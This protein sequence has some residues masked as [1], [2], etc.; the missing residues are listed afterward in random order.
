MA[1]YLIAKI[2]TG[3]HKSVPEAAY[4]S[5]MRCFVVDD[6]INIESLRDITAHLGDIADIEAQYDND[7]PLFMKHSEGS[8]VSFDGVFPPMW[9][10]IVHTTPVEAHVHVVFSRRDGVAGDHDLRIEVKLILRS[11][12]TGFGSGHGRH[13]GNETH[14]AGAE[15]MRIPA[16][17]LVLRAASAI[18]RIIVDVLKSQ[19]RAGNPCLLGLTESRWHEVSETFTSLI[20]H[21]IPQS[22]MQ[23]AIYRKAKAKGRKRE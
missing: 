23:L 9:H 22:A 2:S 4:D 20:S 11:Y 8:L 12:R 21:A 1:N 16:W 19:Y 6:D 15:P 7:E 3:A 5:A 10:A 14:K 17:P 18:T 13:Y